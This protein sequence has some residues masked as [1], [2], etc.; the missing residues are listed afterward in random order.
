MIGDFFAVHNQLAS[1]EPVTG[2]FAVGLGN[3]EAF[4]VGGVALD[5]VQEEGGIIVQVP[6]VE[7]EA[8][9]AVDAFQGGASFLNEGDFECG[10]RGDTGFKGG[11]G[12]RVRALGHAVV[13]KGEESGLVG[14]GKWG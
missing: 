10:F 14:F 1:E 13:D 7:R 5:M 12:F 11:E 3:V 6:V 8:H 4:Y 2:V 9:F